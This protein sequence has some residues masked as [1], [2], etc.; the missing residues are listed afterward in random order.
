MAGINQ[1]SEL[2]CYK[3][4]VCKTNFEFDISEVEHFWISRSH[5]REAV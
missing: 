4:G 5:D 2:S 3:A 1:M